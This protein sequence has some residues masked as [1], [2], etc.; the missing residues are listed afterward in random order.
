MI[1]LA[2][3]H[4]T[5]AHLDPGE[6]DPV[7]LEWL[8][9]EAQREQLYA[10]QEE[11]ERVWVA[12]VGLALE[13]SPGERLV[14]EIREDLASRMRYF[15]VHLEEGRVSD[16]DWDILVHQARLEDLAGARQNAL[17]AAAWTEQG[18][19]AG[20]LPAITGSDDYRR[21]TE[22]APGQV[23]WTIVDG[24]PVATLSEADRDH[25]HRF[26][27]VARMKAGDEESATAS[28]VGGAIT[29]HLSPADLEGLPPV[30]GLSGDALT[31]A[32]WSSH[33]EHP[34]D[35]FGDALARVRAPRLAELT[36]RLVDVTRASFEGG[37]N[38]PFS[39]LFEGTVD[40]QRLKE[41]IHTRTP[42]GT[43][44]VNDDWLGVVN[45][46]LG[47][48]AELSWSKDDFAQNPLGPDTAVLWFKGGGR[49]FRWLVNG[50]GDSGREPLSEL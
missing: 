2:E 34:D 11:D 6:R 49:G 10:A 3:L 46:L 44:V 16:L 32:E 19:R 50:A 37:S 1:T 41:A 31:G 38:E 30:I 9:D 17:L 18:P 26:A 12:I 27:F 47:G 28:L 35:A 8:L 42:A 13:G 7:L 48:V 40:A 23:P 14:E 15:T 39:D 45:Q 25:R 33:L 36:T 20:S 24:R 4:A 5:L 22:A 29:F 43:W 21:F